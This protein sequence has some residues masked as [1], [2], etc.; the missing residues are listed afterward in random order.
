MQDV[1]QAVAQ[2]MQTFRRDERTGSF[3]KWVKTIAYNKIRDHFRRRRAEPAAR[4]GST[5][6]EQLAQLPDVDHDA[7]PQQETAEIGYLFRQATELVRAEVEPKSWQAF[8]QTAVEG[9]ATVDVA[10]DLGVTTNAVRIAKSRI[11]ARLRAEFDGL[12][13]LPESRG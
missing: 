6:L 13:E 1:F 3:R 4:G 12:V 2:N 5:G 9:R 11:R 7:D 8:W 10:A